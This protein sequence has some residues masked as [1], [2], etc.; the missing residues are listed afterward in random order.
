MGET[1]NYYG[2]ENTIVYL[3]LSGNGCKAKIFKTEIVEMGEAERIITCEEAVKIIS[4]FPNMKEVRFE[5]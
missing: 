4:T 3:K 2:Y 1:V 5:R